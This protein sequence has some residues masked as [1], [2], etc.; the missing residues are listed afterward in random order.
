MLQK[1]LEGVGQNLIRAVPDEHLLRRNIV[2]G[3][4]RLAQTGSPRVGI[5]PQ[6]IRRRRYRGQDARRRSIR[7]LVRIEL[8]YAIELRLLTG[9]RRA[10]GR[11]QANSRS[12]S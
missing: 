4:D 3:R 7:I 12:G 11:G 5:E 10:S 9:G 6:T 8:D 2:A 1:R